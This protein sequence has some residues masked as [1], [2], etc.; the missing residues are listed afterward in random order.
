MEDFSSKLERWYKR[1][2]DYLRVCE[3]GVEIVETIP[4]GKLLILIL[5]YILVDSE[6][7]KNAVEWFPSRFIAQL[8]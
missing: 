2:D 1:Q 4:L 6:T 7:L 5:I 3:L 8:K